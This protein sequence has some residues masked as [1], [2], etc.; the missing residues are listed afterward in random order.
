MIEL[1]RHLDG[2]IHI[3]QRCLTKIILNM[4]P[5]MD[6]SSANPTH[7][8]K[9]PIAKN[10]VYQAI[11]NDFSYISVIGLLNSLTNSTRPEVK[12]AVRQIV[13]FSADPKLLYDQAV[14]RVLKYLKGKATQGLIIKP[15]I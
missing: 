3:R 5:G 9:P 6:K 8:V 15:D 7:V 13:W 12:F 10:E 4:I 11:N 1:Y 2:S 14:K